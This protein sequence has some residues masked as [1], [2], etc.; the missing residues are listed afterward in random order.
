MVGP[1]VPEDDSFKCGE[2]V[3]GGHFCSNRCF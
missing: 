3:C 1:D 2:D